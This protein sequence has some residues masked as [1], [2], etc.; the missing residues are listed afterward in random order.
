MACIIDLTIFERDNWDRSRAVQRLKQR[1]R[2]EW[3]GDFLL[4][5]KPNE[6]GIWYCQLVAI[7]WHMFVTCSNPLFITGHEFMAYNV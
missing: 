6:F 3:P 1:W 5:E 7:C 4:T 2:F